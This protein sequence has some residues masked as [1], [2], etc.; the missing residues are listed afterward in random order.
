MKEIYL[1]ARKYC[2]LGLQIQFL[3]ILIISI[4]PAFASAQ[5]ELPQTQ[6]DNAN[7]I[8]EKPTPTKQISPPPTPKT[9]KTRINTSK[10]WKAWTGLIYERIDA[11]DLNSNA[12]A[13]LLSNL[14]PLV[15]AQWLRYFKKGWSYGVSAQMVMMTFQKNISSN[16]RIIKNTDQLLLSGYLDLSRLSLDRTKTRIA[17]GLQEKIF[18]HANP[19]S[20]II[21]DK[22]QIPFLQAEHR[23]NIFSIKQG[24]FG[25]GGSMTYFHSSKTDLYKVKNGFG[26]TLFSDLNFFRT[27][28]SVW[29]A[30]FYYK[31]DNQDSDI[32]KQKSSNL[33]FLISYMGV[34]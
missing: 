31:Q 27:T 19:Q 34:L 29:N 10:R 11:N 13:I 23:L 17:L 25:L 30:Q 15:G 7:A 12:D 28:T 3:A 26:Y 9:K 4:S 32:A 33:G 18:Q 14:S 8:S 2:F 20:D 22:V 1:F 6:P 16:Q 21:L 5:N 24:D